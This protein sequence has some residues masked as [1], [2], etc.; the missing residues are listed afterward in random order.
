LLILPVRDFSCIVES[1]ERFFAGGDVET[2]I[3]DKARVWGEGYALSRVEL[4][5][6]EELGVQ[7]GSLDFDY[8]TVHFDF[9]FETG[10]AGHGVAGR[11]SGCSQMNR[12][13][14]RGTGAV[15]GTA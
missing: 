4:C 9:D 5:V 1:F 8:H 7:P 10:H 6:G 2:I 3:L 14:L 12:D 13:D 11:V 15:R